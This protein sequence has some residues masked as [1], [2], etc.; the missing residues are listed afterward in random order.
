MASVTFG[1][2]GDIVTACFLARD[3][4]E[5]LDKVRG[6]A[7]EHQALAAELR[8][9]DRALLETVLL[10]DRHHASLGP[11]AG[12]I[13]NECQA[14]KSSL[15][16][17]QEVAAKYDD[18]F[19]QD[20]PTLAVKRIGRS[21]RWRFVE[22]E[23]LARF[24]GE[25]SCHFN[26]LSML[27]VTANISLSLGALEAAAGY[28]TPS[29]FNSL[30][31]LKKEIQQNSGLLSSMN[32]LL[33]QVFGSIGML[34]KLMASIKST[35]NQA[36]RSS[37]TGLNI[38]L[39][40]YHV[41]SNIQES[42]ASP[43]ERYSLIQ[44]PFILD[45]ALGRIAPVHL[46]FITSW[47]ALDK[48][49]QL[50]FKGMQGSGKVKRKEF[51]LQERATGREISRRLPW[52]T[53]FR[54]G[55][56]VEMSLIFRESVKATGML[57]GRSTTNPCPSCGTLPNSEE[58]RGI[59]CIECGLTYRRTRE[60]DKVTTQSRQKALNMNTPAINSVQ[61]QQRRISKS[62]LR[63]ERRLK[64]KMDEL[65]HYR[66]VLGSFKRIRILSTTEIQETAAP[67]AKEPQGI[68]IAVVVGTRPHSLEPFWQLGTFDQ[69]LQ[70]KVSHNLPDVLGNPQI[71][72]PMENYVSFSGNAIALGYDNPALDSCLGR[73]HATSWDEPRGGGA[74]LGVF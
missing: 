73:S 28:Q 60:I 13:V 62:E 2:F 1:S 50:R 58:K 16:R 35:V 6:S 41:V 24:K 46:Q 42:L 66:A 19:R 17:L 7:G 61:Q 48:V 71:F 74:L 57:E 12:A 14:C 26:A 44:E 32:G 11:S 56:T 72:R 23:V 43:L 36:L 15:Q 10:L 45:D 30:Q 64:R 47:G 68:T 3:I 52:E 8:S 9:L 22:R 37:Q 51:A 20:A 54:P 18:A 53:A 25:I 59:T 4:A 21:L 33:C 49:L 31:I 34:T 29:S 63:K 70:D 65:H 27:L 69:N 67:S 38:S 40:T 5:C 55:Q 39:A